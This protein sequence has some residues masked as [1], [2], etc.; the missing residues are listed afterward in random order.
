LALGIGANGAIFSLIEQMLLRPLPVTEPGQLVNLHSPGPKP[1]SQS[2]TGMGNEDQIFSYLMYRDLEAAVASGG[3]AEVAFT[4]LAAHRV[5]SANLAFEGRTVSASGLLVSGSYFSVLGLQPAAGRL[6]APGDDRDIGAHAVAVLS[7]AYW[8]S[9]FGEDPSVVGKTL[10]VNGHPMTIIGVAPKGFVGTSLG[11]QARIFVPLSMRGVLSPGF[12]GFESRRTYWAYAFGR[13][14]PG[15]S[16]EAARA[17]LNPTYRRLILDVEA[18][19]QSGMSDKTLEVFKSKELLLS[20]GSRGQSLIHSEIRTPLGIMLG[21]TGL[22]LLIAAANLANLFLVRASDRAGEIAIRMSIGARRLQVVAQML[23]ESFVLATAGA[24]L[25]VGVSYATIRGISELLPRER[26]IFSTEA[27]PT[28]WVFMLFLVVLTGL[29]GLFPA[30]HSTRREF[31]TVLRSQSGRSSDSRGAARFRSSMVTLQIAMSVAL[32]AAAGLFTKS[33]ANISQVDL[34]LEIDELIT[35]SISP[36]LNGYEHSESAVL[37]ERV[38]EEVGALPGVVGV[39]ASL[40]PLVNSSNW[41]T[42][43]SVQGFPADPDTDVHSNFS[44]IGPGFFKTVGMELLAGREFTLSDEQGSE[45][46]AI[47]NESFVEK[48]NLGGDVLGTMIAQGTGSGVELDTRVVGLVRDAAY[49][50]V[51]G[52]VPPIF[53]IP[54]R[55]TE[56]GGLN[57]YVRS[58]LPAETLLPAVRGVVN[59][60]DPN[61]PL[62]GRTMEMQVEENVFLDHV[63]GSMSTA[64]AVLATLLAAIGLYGVLAYSVS[65]RSKEIGLRMA[66]GA[67]SHRVRTMVL[68]QVSW[69]TLFGV[70]L[71]LCGAV[72]IG[73]VAGAL[74]FELDGHD[75]AVLTGAT[76]IIAAISLLA[77]FIPAQKAAR[78]DPIHA[79]RDD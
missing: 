38:R 17:A 24:V 36:E 16:V 60:L 54:H 69:M 47:V 76:A 67:D 71:G 55:Q 61:L 32:L 11:F 78:T 9:G 49:S 73:R 1:G 79:L 74:L 23:A 10:I 57:F 68:R 56:R 58:T 66:L 62:E 20:S 7:H 45:K 46:V 26:V 25:G 77:G 2:T 41:G 6:I 28:F 13:L 29:V 64:F 35:F 53:Y 65:Q 51:K 31:S 50:E 75:P 42:S 72:G 48:F 14:K 39:S 4:G 34:G 40:V 59:R 70:I 52:Q 15:V 8:Q 18:P 33:L 44:E 12:D 3:P 19:E 27:G 37:F 43:L 30:L 21:A 5:L 63:L 22:V